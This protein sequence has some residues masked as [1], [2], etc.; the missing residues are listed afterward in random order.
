MND[1]R[2]HSN[3]DND[4]TKDQLHEQGIDIEYGSRTKGEQVEKE[5]A[6]EATW[7]IGIPKQDAS[8][9]VI[10]ASESENQGESN[11]IYGGMSQ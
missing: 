3:G 4:L 9:K 11:D 7:P 6:E 10:P 2:A 1:P 5:L 8:P